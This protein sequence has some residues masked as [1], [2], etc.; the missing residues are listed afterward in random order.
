[1]SFAPEK[2]ERFNALSDH[3]IRVVFQPGCG[4]GHRLAMCKL[5]SRYLL[6]KPE[7]LLRRNGRVRVR[8]GSSRNIGVRTTNTRG[9]LELEG[10]VIPTQN[11]VSVESCRPERNSRVERKD[12][13]TTAGPTVIRSSVHNSGRRYEISLWD[14]CVCKIVSNR[15]TAAIHIDFIHEVSLRRIP[16]RYCP[17][18][19]VSQQG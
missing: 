4:L 13:S 9:A 6:L 19:G 5:A 7:E 18:K 11:D 3:I 16:I 1:M 17:V 14:R 8:A 10:R 12:C 15:E 2:G